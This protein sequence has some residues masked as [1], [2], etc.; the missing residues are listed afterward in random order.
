MPEIPGYVPLV[1]MGALDALFR[2]LAAF[3]MG[4]AVGW[5]R[6][7]LG[8]P[9]GLRTHIMVA[10]GACA[11]LI[12]GL[13]LLAGYGDELDPTRVLQGVVG[14][15]GFLGAGSI[16]QSRGNATGVTTAATLWVT[17]AIGAGC[18]FGQYVLALLLV[19]FCLL[20]LIALGRLEFSLSEVKKTQDPSDKSG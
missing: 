2:L 12:M 9:A 5:N 15:I 20:A 1:S 18:G 7:R 17:G 13:E 4:G 3:V 10:L 19:S 14:G 16:I 11:F 8:K 6:E